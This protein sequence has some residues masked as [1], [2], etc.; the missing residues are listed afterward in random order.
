MTDSLRGHLMSRGWPDDAESLVETL[1]WLSGVYITFPLDLAELGSVSELPG[2]SL[3]KPHVA[4]FLQRMV[5]VSHVRDV[6]G[7]IA[8]SCVPG[9]NEMAQATSKM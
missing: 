7:A 9:A 6:A 4:A 1:R 2:A 3:L 5:E 8:C